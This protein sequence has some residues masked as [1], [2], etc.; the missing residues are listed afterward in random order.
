VEILG[1]LQRNALWQALAQSGLLLS[2]FSYQSSDRGPEVI[3]THTPSGSFYFIKKEGY[4]YCESCVGSD[5]VSEQRG[6]PDFAEIVEDVKTWG[7][8][9][10]QWLDAPDLWKLSSGGTDVP[11][12]LVSESANSPFT[13][14]EQAAISARL[15]QVAESIKKTYELTAEQSAK[16]DEKFEE[17]EKASR[18][19]GRKDWGLLFG[20][21]VFS[22]ILADAITPGIAGHILIMIEHGLGHLFGGPAVG[23]VLNA[24]QD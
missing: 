14:D 18:R 22:L 17:A 6:G 8:E 9:I 23:G 11:G 13:S 1:K 7:S 19:M 10:S 24:G 5:P 3:I 21:A 20:G 4:F 12:N 15:K 2:E 16:L